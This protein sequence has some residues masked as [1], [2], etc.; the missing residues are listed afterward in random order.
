MRLVIRRSEQLTQK[1]TYKGVVNML[2]ETN[3]DYQNCL[4][5]NFYDNKT[6]GVFDSWEEFKEKHYGFMSDG[7]D[8]T[9]NFVFRYDIHKQ[10]NDCYKLELCMMLQRKGI[11]SNLTIK[12]I[13]QNILNIEVYEWLKGRS[14]YIKNL[15]KEVIG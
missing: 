15:W 7:F 11:Y 3:H 12:N 8:D 9:Y 14:E 6:T 13:T 2:K 1:A 5:G 10:D 4:V